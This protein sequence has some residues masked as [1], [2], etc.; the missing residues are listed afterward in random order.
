AVADLDVEAVHR[1]ALLPRVDARR[2]VECDCCHGVFPSPAGTCRTVRCEVS[3][4]GLLRSRRGGAPLHRLPQCSAA[5]IGLGPR[6]S[7]VSQGTMREA[8]EGYSHGETRWTGPDTTRTPLQHVRF[9]C[10]YQCMIF[11]LA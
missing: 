5:L 4:T 7:G 1:R 9:N 11:A 8:D 2:I 10:S 6:S 3:V